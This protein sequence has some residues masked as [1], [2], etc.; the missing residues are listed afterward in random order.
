M[1]RFAGPPWTPRGGTRVR[2]P[3]GVAGVPATI[4][5]VTGVLR[6]TKRRPAI[7]RSRSKGSQLGTASTL[8][9]VLGKRPGS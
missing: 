8:T 7:W 3:A 2:A 1:A 4:P 5:C 9:L 6:G